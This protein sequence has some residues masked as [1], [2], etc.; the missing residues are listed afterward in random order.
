MHSHYNPYEIAQAQFD[1]MADKISLDGASRQLL[2]QPSHEYHLT[3]PVKMNGGS[4]RIFN[5]Y[6]IHHN[7]ARGSAKGGIRFHPQETADTIKALSMLMTWK[8]AVVDVPLGGG[9]GGIVCDPRELS[10]TE[11]ERLC[12]GYIRQL[13]KNMGPLTD[14][15]APDVMSNGQHMLWMLDEYE[16][17]SGGQRR[18]LPRSNHGQAGSYGRIF[19]TYGGDRIRRFI[20]SERS[21]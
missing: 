18:P 7:D 10:M 17:I 16:V 5:A 6:R 11:Q 14:L 15:P 12:R 20:Y 2:R 4:T 9:K 19:G 3:I 1:L 8:C 21:T 13:S